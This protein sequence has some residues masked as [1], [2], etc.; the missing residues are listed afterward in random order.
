MREKGVVFA[1]LLVIFCFL[2]FVA[3]NA[4]CQ[5]F[6]ERII[7]HHFGIV[8]KIINLSNLGINF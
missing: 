6:G 4:V 2:C 3:E 1:K 5:A 8:A 7:V